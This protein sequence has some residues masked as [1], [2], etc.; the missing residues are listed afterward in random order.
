MDHLVIDQADLPLVNGAREWQ[1]YI[2]GGIGISLIL[3]VR[4]F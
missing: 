1:G 4:E 2:F 3:T